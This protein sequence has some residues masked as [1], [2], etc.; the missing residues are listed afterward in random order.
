MKAFL[1][2]AR[3]YLD[4]FHIWT[5][6]KYLH[7]PFLHHWSSS[8]IS[9]KFPHF[10]LEKHLLWNTSHLAINLHLFPPMFVRYCCLITPYLTGKY[11]TNKTQVIVYRPMSYLSC[12][13]AGHEKVELTGQCGFLAICTLNKIVILGHFIL[14]YTTV[15]RFRVSIGHYYYIYIF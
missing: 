13:H 10:Y 6:S 15:Q 2:C 3:V 7:H 9:L 14:I 1:S 4:C 5:A 11:V 12:Y 8:G